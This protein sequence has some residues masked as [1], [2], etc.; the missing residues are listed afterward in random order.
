M[1]R[2]I[3]YC[4]CWIVGFLLW[5]GSVV[6]TCLSKSSDVMVL[7]GIAFAILGIPMFGGSLF[8]LFKFYLQVK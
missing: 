7:F 2:F 6:P 3:V 1:K 8:A 4:L 5:Y